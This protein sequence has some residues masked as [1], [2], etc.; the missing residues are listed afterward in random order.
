M[1]HDANFIETFN[2][3]VDLSLFTHSLRKSACF[4]SAFKVSTSALSVAT[5]F[6]SWAI[7]ASVLGA[8]EAEEA[9]TVSNI[10]V[11]KTAAS[12]FFISTPSSMSRGER[13]AKITAKVG[14]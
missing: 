3:F 14:N 9:G 7:L 8:A 2:E 12:N 5:C 6:S 11:I 1:V 13:V 10:S 4:S